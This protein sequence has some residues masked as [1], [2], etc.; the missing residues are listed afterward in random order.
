MQRI[1]TIGI[2]RHLELGG[3]GIDGGGELGRA[4]GGP[5]GQG[6]RAGS[7]VLPWE[8]DVAARRGWRSGADC[9]VAQLFY[10]LLSDYRGGAVGDSSPGRDPDRLALVD[11]DLRRGAGTR[12]A[13]DVELSP[14]GA[15]FDRVAVHRGAGKR[16]N[17][18][19]RRQVRC[20]HPVQRALDRDRLGRVR[21]DGRKD[22][23]ARVRD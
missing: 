10:V 13:D 5:F 1:A 11:A 2:L 17:V 23:R 21:P 16:G 20:E 6:R 12:L 18:A 15:G 8:S 14:G 22:E 9:V 3:A 4:D 7:L 19:G